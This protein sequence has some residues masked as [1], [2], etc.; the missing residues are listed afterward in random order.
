MNKKNFGR[1]KTRH[2]LLKARKSKKFSIID[3]RRTKNNGFGGNLKFPY[4]KDKKYPL[5]QRYLTEFFGTFQ[6][7]VFFSVQK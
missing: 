5:N 2:F 1:Q 3:K 7:F 4:K 6:C